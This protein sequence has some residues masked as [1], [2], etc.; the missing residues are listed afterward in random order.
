MTTYAKSA[1]GTT[2]SWNSQD[3]AEL[4]EISPP[5]T[6]LSMKEVTNNDS[7]GWVER[8][9]GLLDGGD[10]SIKGNFY[11]GDTDGQIALQAD[12]IAKTARTAVITL[13]AAF[14]TTLTMTAYCTEFGLITPQNDGAEVSFEAS[15]SITGTPTFTVATSTGLTTP[16]FA[17]SAG[18][19]IPAAAGSTYTYVVD[20]GTAETSIT[21]T[22]T[23]AAGTITVNGNTVA[24]GVASSA[25]TL[26]AA[27]SVTTVTIVVTETSKAPVTYT[28]YVARAAAP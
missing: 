14:G 25:I 13:P 24:T 7:G 28:L 27:G 19:I 8:I 6:K 18:T 2:L 17:V 23:A 5:K 15:F 21:V 11:A 3:I 4:T 16:F 26:G 12:H 9:A 20:V 1:H 10:F 22:P